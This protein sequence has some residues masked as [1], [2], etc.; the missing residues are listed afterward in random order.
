MVSYLTTLFQGKPPGDSLPVF[1]A[2]SLASNRQFVLEL[3]KEEKNSLTEC[4]RREGRSQGRLHIGRPDSS[5]G[6][7]FGF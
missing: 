4:A 5:V 3:A 7:A 1:S 6:S 2:H